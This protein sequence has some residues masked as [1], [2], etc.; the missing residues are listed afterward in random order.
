MSK[1]Q[2]KASGNGKEKKIDAEDSDVDDIDFDNFKGIYFGDKHEKYQDP[3]TGCHFEYNNL[4]SRLHK[5]REKRKVL[6]L[7][8][9]LKS[10]TRSTKATSVRNH[11]LEEHRVE[12]KKGIVVT[13]QGIQKLNASHIHDRASAG[14]LAEDK[15]SQDD[16]KQDKQA[17]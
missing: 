13:K 16:E 11:S 6:D 8:L 12:V 3:V 7:Q 5:L 17:R 9:G 10:P 14:R 4:C 2:A 1:A 15:N